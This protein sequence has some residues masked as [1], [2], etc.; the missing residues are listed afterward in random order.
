MG[1][2]FLN[3]YKKF[4]RVRIGGYIQPQFQAAQEKGAKSFDPPG[5]QKDGNDWVLI[6]E[7]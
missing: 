6:L 4:D 2:G 3:L 5:E 1:K 7:K